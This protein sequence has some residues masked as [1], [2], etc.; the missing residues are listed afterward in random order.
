MARLLVA[1]LQTLPVSLQ[2]HLHLD[3]KVAALMVA[4][5]WLMLLLWFWQLVLL[6]SIDG[7]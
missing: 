5:D 3:F 7:R 6:V 2:V 4:L 1:S